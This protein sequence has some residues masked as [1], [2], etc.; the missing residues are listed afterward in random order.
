VIIT[1]DIKYTCAL[2][3]SVFKLGLR[4]FIPIMLIS[5]AATPFTINGVHAQL[6]GSA[7]QQFGPE[8]GITMQFSYYP[9]NPTI[10]SF[11]TFT[12]NVTNSTT[13]EPL[14]NFVATVMVGN[15][16]NF[17]GGSSFYNF[18][19]ITVPNG[20]FSVNYAFPNDGTFPVYLRVDTPST[21]SVARFQVFVP[22]PNVIPSNDYTMIYVGIAIAAG[23]A[24]IGIVMMQKRKTKMR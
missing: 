17:I 16:V 15:V 3:K 14:Q 10:N 1:D 21:I 20:N 18:S 13:Q 23:G 5:A 12:F 8:H 19:K 4:L 22:P 2:I 6:E 9:A 11:T 24:G 7:V